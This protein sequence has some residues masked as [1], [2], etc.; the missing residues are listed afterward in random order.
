MPDGRTAPLPG[1]CPHCDLSPSLQSQLVPSS[2]AGP[3]PEDFSQAG[4]GH[5]SQNS[6]PPTWQY[7]VLD[8]VPRDS[9]PG[10]CH[11]RFPL[12][13][14]ILGAAPNPADF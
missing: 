1:F 11:P 4:L 2:A 12:A 10:Q 7:L 8:F 6:E 9:A 14:L 3:Y 5:T 13:L